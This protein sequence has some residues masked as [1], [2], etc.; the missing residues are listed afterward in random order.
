MILGFFFFFFLHKFV[1]NVQQT[2][3]QHFILPVGG[4]R[5]YGRES[6]MFNRNEIRPPSQAQRAA[7]FLPDFLIPPVAGGP[8]RWPSL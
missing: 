7:D 2:S 3:G 6:Q 4:E 5:C 8:S 1:L